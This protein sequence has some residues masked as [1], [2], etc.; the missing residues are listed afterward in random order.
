MRQL[1]CSS[2]STSPSTNLFSTAHSDHEDLPEIQD[3]CSANWTTIQYIPGEIRHDWAK[4]FLTE[5]RN[6]IATPNTDSLTKIFLLSK[7]V[8]AVPIRGG[9]A[10]AE[11]VNRLL[12]K[13][14]QLWEAGQ[15]STLWND[16]KSSFQ[17]LTAGAAKRYREGGL[18]Q[19]DVVPEQLSAQG[20]SPSAKENRRI[21]QMVNN[22]LISRACRNLL[23][24]GIAS[25]SLVKIES[26]FPSRPIDELSINQVPLTED[27]EISSEVVKN[28]I[29]SFS[30]GVAP[31]PSGLRADHVK[32]AILD[33]RDKVGEQL[34]TTLAE[35]VKLLT[36]GRLSPQL[37]PILCGGR[38]IP[39]L[40]KDAGVRPIVIGECLRAIAAKALLKATDAG[41][42]EQLHPL[43][44]GVGHA[45]DG[46]P[47]AIFTVRS[48][49]P[50]PPKA[51][52][53]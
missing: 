32:A 35:L 51:K 5:L 3:I 50:W 42:L 23:S 33:G 19:A 37:Q 9:K 15:L 29:L 34:L 26:L 24:R 11:A 44:L 6:F 12:R 39:L 46:I 48:S 16:V 27:V 14:L 45:I 30:A 52:Y 53:C 10:R 43:Q 4:A 28:V 41:E 1:A 8:L 22:G 40:K 21:V 20:P 25:H 7:A 13:R 31:G 49:P 38:L 47:T 18:V 17:R 36:A 2:N